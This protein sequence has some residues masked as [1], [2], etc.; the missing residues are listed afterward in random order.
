MEIKNFVN[1]INWMLE[2][3]V[4]EVDLAT[5]ITDDGI[6]INQALLMALKETKFKLMIE[7]LSK[8]FRE[9]GQF[10]SFREKTEMFVIFQTWFNDYEKKIMELEKGSLEFNIECVFLFSAKDMID[11]MF[12][13]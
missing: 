6:E 4:E 2:P 3:I 9:G 12:E 7:S 8:E 11:V 1:K 5:K 13:G 10:C